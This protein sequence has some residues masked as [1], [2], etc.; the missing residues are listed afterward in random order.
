M[1]SDSSSN[2][3]RLRKSFACK[4]LTAA[5][6]LFVSNT[7]KAIVDGISRSVIEHADIH[8]STV[9]ESIEARVPGSKQ[10][11]VTLTTS[12]GQ[13][14]FDEVVVTVPLVSNAESL[15]LGQIINVRLG[16][17]EVRHSEVRSGSSAEY[18]ASH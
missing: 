8:L 10:E 9:V 12:K 3:F 1:L 2:E 15:P 5:D 14:E 7:H 13:F 16:M 6:N 17:L 4:L 11:K 18:R